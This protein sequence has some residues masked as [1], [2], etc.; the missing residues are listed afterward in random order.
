MIFFLVCGMSFLVSHPFFQFSKESP[1]HISV[2][3]IVFN[4]E[5]KIAC[6]HFKNKLGEKDLYILMRESVENGEDLLT[7]LERGLMEEFGAKAKPLSYVGALSG[8]IS[9]SKTDFEK[10]TLYIACKLTSFNPDK[11]DENDPEADSIIEW[12]DP[13]ELIDIM[14]KQGD[15]YQRIDLD[16]STVIQRALDLQK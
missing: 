11:R 7:T 3:A 4:D 16:E 8:T 5:G 15:K 1:Y 6:H 2:G 13:K 9:D 14:Q 12:M 10:T